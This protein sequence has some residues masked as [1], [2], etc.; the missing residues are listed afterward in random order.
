MT[1]RKIRI[2]PDPIL[3]TK[4]RTVRRIDDDVRTLARDMVETLLDAEGVGL[5]ANQVGALKRVIALHLPEE[6]PYWLVNPEITRKEGERTVTEGC[7]SVP[8]YEGLVTRSVR[9]TV[10]ALDEAGAKWRVSAEEL[11]AQALEHEI[12]HLNGI[13][14]M[15][16]LLEHERLR[17]IGAEDP[18]SE[19]HMHDVTY[20]IHTRDGDDAQ[21]HVHD[22]SDT[23]LLVARARLSEVTPHHSMS[24]LSYD[25]SET[26]T[27]AK[28]D[29]HSS[30]R[31]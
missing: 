12:D 13:M 9:V 2:F 25:L 26:N 23:E 21:D 22:D 30:E 28:G 15:D 4:C 8:G 6:E 1:I 27:L 5:A 11:L 29:Q 7:L 31:D 19:T 18:E 20:E 3:R 14:Y 24:E 17:E 16:H 10:R